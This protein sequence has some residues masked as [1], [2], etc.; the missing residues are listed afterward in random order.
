MSQMDGP[1]KELE[2]DLR[3]IGARLTANLQLTTAQNAEIVRKSLVK[4]IQ[5]QDLHW[6]KLN[7]RYL[8]SKRR[9]RLSTAILIATSEFMQSITTQIS[10]D[11]L[12]AF[13]G[14]LRNAKRKDGEPGVLIAELHEFGSK[15]RNIP[16]RPLFRPT[17]AEIKP[18]VTDRFKAAIKEVLETTGT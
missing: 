15:A 2:D 8:E 13:V 7:P 12:S 9:R 18:E 4:H 14:V 11:K 5:N 1:W 16:A 17:F 3:G 10:S 6:A